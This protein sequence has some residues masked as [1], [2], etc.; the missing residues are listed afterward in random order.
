MIRIWARTLAGYVYHSSA[1]ARDGAREPVT[2]FFNLF[3]KY[4]INKNTSCTFVLYRREK[5]RAF[6][7]VFTGWPSCF[8]CFAGAD[9]RFAKNPLFVFLMTRNFV[10]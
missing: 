4:A 8:L 3:V 6:G 10:Y 1:S 7:S 5:Y 9:T 2:R